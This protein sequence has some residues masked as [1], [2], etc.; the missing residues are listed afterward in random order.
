M[1]SELQILWVRSRN[2]EFLVVNEI[3]Q[4]WTD[5]KSKFEQNVFLNYLNDKWYHE[6]SFIIVQCQCKNNSVSFG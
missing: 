1:S 4:T 3:L 2:F 6:I 5:R